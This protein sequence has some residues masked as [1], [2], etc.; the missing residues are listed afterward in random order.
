MTIDIEKSLKAKLRT[1]AKERYRDPADVWQAVVLERF[2]VR[3]ARSRHRQH[4]I[5]KGGILLSHYI[6]I[7]RET[8]DLDFLGLN[9]SSQTDNLKVV[10]EE[11]ISIDLS[12]GFNFRDVAV[13]E[14]PHPHMFYT[15]I[16]VSM[17]AY[18]GR[19]RFR[20]AIDVGF[21][22]V[23]KP[24]DKKL[25]LIDYSKGPLFEGDI[26]LSCYPKEYIF[27][28]KLETVV[29]RGSLNSRMKDFHDLY[30][31]IT[32]TLLSFNDLG[33]ITRAVFQH[34]GTALD[35]PLTYSHD[36][37]AQLQAIWESYL[38]NLRVQTVQPLPKDIS[39]II[40]LLN[41]YLQVHV[42]RGVLR[43]R[44]LEKDDSLLSEHQTDSVSV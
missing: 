27:A 26:T 6:S 34:R 12:D 39:T 4:F 8:K 10:F 36:Q 20:V 23:I 19:I 24:I 42:S 30:S 2:L 31:M 38:R 37:V 9:T 43:G 18:F 44:E 29:Y 7:G 11:I 41:D 25:K 17:I 40:Q 32:S 21:G 28:E 33:G 5:L 3:L 22:D 15:G 1:V 13:T 35:L 16:E 14:L